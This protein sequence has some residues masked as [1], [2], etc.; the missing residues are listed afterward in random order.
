MSISHMSYLPPT[1]RAK[2]QKNPDL[3]QSATM[4]TRCRGQHGQDCVTDFQHSPGIMKNEVLLDGQDDDSKQSVDG[5]PVKVISFG[6]SKD[7]SNGG[8]KDEEDTESDAESDAE[9]GAEGYPAE[10]AEEQAEKELD[11]E[12]QEDRDEGDE[13]QYKH[14]QEDPDI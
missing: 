12:E 11:E 10:Q 4:V 1:S 14:D 9:G 8:G 2:L 7:K 3:K 13:Q 5:K 6:A